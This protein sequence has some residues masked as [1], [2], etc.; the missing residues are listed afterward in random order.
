MLTLNDKKN[1]ISVFIDLKKA[2]D[3]VNHSILLRNLNCYGIRG[4]P[5]ENFTSN[6]SD[7][8]QCVR[9]GDKTSNYQTVNIGVPC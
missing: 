5:L 9:V 7:R 6:I 2:F 4:L 3:T 8:K 1:S